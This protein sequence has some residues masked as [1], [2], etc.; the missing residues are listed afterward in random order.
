MS[1]TFPTPREVALERLGEVFGPPAETWHLPEALQGNEDFDPERDDRWRLPDWWGLRPDRSVTFQ[2]LL[3]EIAELPDASLRDDD[4]WTSGPTPQVITKRKPFGCAYLAAAPARR[5]VLY[6]DTEYRGRTVKC[7]D[8]GEWEISG[9]APFEAWTLQRTGDPVN[10]WGISGETTREAGRHSCHPGKGRFD[11]KPN[12]RELDDWQGQYYNGSRVYGTAY[13]A[14]KKLGFIDALD[15][16]ISF[17]EAQEWA[18]GAAPK[19]AWLDGEKPPEMQ[20][21]EIGPDGRMYR[22]G[23]NEAPPDDD[24]DE[25]LDVL[26][27]VTLRRTSAKNAL[28]DVRRLRTQ[29]EEMRVQADAMEKSADL[30]QVQA[31]TERA[32]VRTQAGRLLEL[33]KADEDFPGIE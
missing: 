26:Q 22:G 21:G 19:P 2:A 4:N 33:L 28:S 30:R 25:L 29:A 11:R 10:E 17:I 14:L 31:D 9:T 24:P 13:I 7:V 3:D 32:G 15:V 8:E 6:E 18:A 12:Y 5:Q 1:E 20:V 16:A 23:S 27:D